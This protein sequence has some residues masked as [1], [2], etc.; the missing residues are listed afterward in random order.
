MKIVGRLYSQLFNCLNVK[1]Y[2][3]A[4]VL[5]AQSKSSFNSSSAVCY[6]LMSFVQELDDSE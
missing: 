4:S 6:T 5:I 2:K 3:V 1:K